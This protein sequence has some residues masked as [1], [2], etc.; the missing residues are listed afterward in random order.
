MH[1]TGSFHISSHLHL[2]PHISSREGNNTY[3][4]QTNDH[5]IN[6]SKYRQSF[7]TSRLYEIVN[8]IPMK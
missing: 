1:K 4:L 5:Q 6:Q 7:G 3:R 8:R 2:D